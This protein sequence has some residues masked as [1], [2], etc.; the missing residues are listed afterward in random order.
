MFLE[1]LSDWPSPKKTKFLL[2]FSIVLFIVI[3]PI[4]GYFFLISNYPVDFITSQLSC[5]G[6]ILKSHYQTTNIELY[7][8]GQI[9]DYGYMV[10]YGTLIFSLALIIARKFNEPSIWRKSGYIIA[11][12]G[13][14]AACCDG[15]EN[16]FILAMLTD[17][18][19]FPDIWALTHSCFALVKWT[20][21]FLSISWAII[22][23]LI[24]VMKKK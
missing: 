8:I 14:I 23:A 20:I 5:S 9:L 11:I 18:S 4:M 1:K 10:S 15:I 17:P 21:L 3:F 22:A 6:D 24:R 7:R 16:A 2:I 19:G 13:I 12:L